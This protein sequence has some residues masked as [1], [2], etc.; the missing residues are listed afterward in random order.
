[1]LMY[2]KGRALTGPAPLKINGERTLFLRRCRLF[3]QNL[4]EILV[5]NRVPFL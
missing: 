3:L 1:M 5:K 4:A 2:T